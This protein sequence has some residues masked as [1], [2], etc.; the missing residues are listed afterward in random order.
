MDFP[1]APGAAGRLKLDKA[2]Q[3]YWP[4]Q[5]VMYVLQPLSKLEVLYLVH[6][7]E[8]QAANDTFGTTKSIDNDSIP[9]LAQ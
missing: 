5:M 8:T 7:N 2:R 6:M 1:R 3:N 9:K 4:N